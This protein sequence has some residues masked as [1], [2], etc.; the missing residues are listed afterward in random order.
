[1]VGPA[2]TNSLSSDWA[3]TYL[4]AKTEN[5]EIHI[6]AIRD[7]VNQFEEVLISFL[8]TGP[9]T[10]VC[11]RSTRHKRALIVEW[12]LRFSNFGELNHDLDIVR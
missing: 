3:M 12:S 9:R 8:M 2:G 1:M 4:D 7:L 5:P 6:N 10:Y 11:V